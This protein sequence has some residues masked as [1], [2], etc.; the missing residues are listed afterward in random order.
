MSFSESNINSILNALEE[1]GITNPYVQA[2]I[3][4]T[5]AKENQIQPQSEN[6]RYTSVARLRKVWPNLF[7]TDESA[8]PYI[9]NPEKLGNFVYGGKFGNAQ[10]EGYK[11]RGRGYNG[12][13]FKENYRRYGQMIGKDLVSN[14]DLVNN[15]EIAAKILAI[16]Y[17]D[18]MNKVGCRPSKYTLDQSNQIGNLDS[19]VRVSVAV[20]AGCPSSLR[21]NIISEDLREASEYANVL[22]PYALRRKSSSKGVSDKSRLPYIILG[23]AIILI[24]VLIIIYRKKIIHRD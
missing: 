15:P 20:T 3:L 22:L 11:Y 17:K 8:K 5:T 13:T 18:M 1:Q 6:L 19:A 23:M 4:A 9:N 10:N 24:I 12:L 21:G 2:G 16:F 7:P 14:P